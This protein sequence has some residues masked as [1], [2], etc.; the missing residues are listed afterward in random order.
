MR[1]RLLAIADMEYEKDV[2]EALIIQKLKDEGASD[3][4]VGEE[5]EA[6]EDEEEDAGE[7]GSVFHDPE[8]IVGRPVKTKAE[9]EP[10]DVATASTKSNPTQG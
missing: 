10:V 3:S 9:D 2:K 6:E 8:V 7:E 4:L 1:I 5:R